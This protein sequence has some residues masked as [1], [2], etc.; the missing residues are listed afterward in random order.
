MWVP[1]KKKNKC[2]LC[3]MIVRTEDPQSGITFKISIEQIVKILFQGTFPEKF[4]TVLVLP[5]CI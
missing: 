3:A 2:R 5:P 1:E 4:H